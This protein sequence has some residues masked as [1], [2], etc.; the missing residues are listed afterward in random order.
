MTS[1]EEKMHSVSTQRR[2]K[3]PAGKRPQYAELRRELETELEELAPNER[4]FGE[5]SLRDL[6]PGA[7]RRAQQILDVL[8]RMDSDDFGLCVACRSPIS[9]ER[10]SIIP[11]TRL[12]AQCSWS[13]E[14]HR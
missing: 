11:E 12:C 7:R 3:G 6:A 9:E 8:H 5:E 14:L 10:L 2:T 1:T 4:L 13:R